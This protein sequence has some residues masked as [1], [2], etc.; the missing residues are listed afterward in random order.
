MYSSEESPL[1]EGDRMHIPHELDS[2]YSRFSK[3]QKNVVV[4]TVSLAGLL[5]SVY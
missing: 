3:T 4:F 1:L 5:P 2:V